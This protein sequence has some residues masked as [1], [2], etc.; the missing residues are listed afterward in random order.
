MLIDAAAW[1]NFHQ[2]VRVC[3]ATRVPLVPMEGA[4]R[5]LKLTAEDLRTLLPLSQGA[6]VLLLREAGVLVTPGEIVGQRGLVRIAFDQKIEV[7]SQ[8]MDRIGEAL[9]GLC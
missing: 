2:L 8:A 3:G 6:R 5:H 4:R 9:T 7:V 1:M